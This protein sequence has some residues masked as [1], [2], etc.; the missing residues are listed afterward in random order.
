MGRPKK[1]GLEQSNPPSRFKTLCDKYRLLNGRLSIKELAEKL[2]GKYNQPIL[3]QYETQAK[4]PPLEIVEK[5][6]DF[7]DLKNEDRFDFYLAALE[8]SKKTEKLDF[9]KIDLSFLIMFRKFL[10]FILSDQDVGFI[11]KVCEV[12]AG[13]YSQEQDKECEV[14]FS[15]WKSLKSSFTNFIKEATKYHPRPDNSLASPQK[16]YHQPNYIPMGEKLE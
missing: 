8:A 4:G 14:L 13:Y 10:A 12:N 15:A 3:S 6:A 16:E 2:G 9:S 1:N 5:Y 7:F 11:F